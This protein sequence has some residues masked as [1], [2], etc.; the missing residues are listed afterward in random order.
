MEFGKNIVGTKSE[1]SYSRANWKREECS[2]VVY[3]WT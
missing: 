1:T 3:R 2:L